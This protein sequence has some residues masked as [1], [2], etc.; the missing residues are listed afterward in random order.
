MS[1]LTPS[2][3]KLP[4]SLRK[5]EIFFSYVFCDLTMLSPHGLRIYWRSNYLENDLRSSFSLTSLKYLN[6]QDLTLCANYYSRI[7]CSILNRSVM[8]PVPF[9]MPVI[10]LNPEILNYGAL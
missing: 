3:A 6:F 2:K 9:R 8:G 4:H 5:P 7:M 10:H 1:R